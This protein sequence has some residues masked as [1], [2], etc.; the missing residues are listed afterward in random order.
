MSN[1]IDKKSD[2]INL[3]IAFSLLSNLSMSINPHFILST[4]SLFFRLI[5]HKIQLSKH[6]L[7]SLPFKQKIYHSLSYKTLHSFTNINP[8]QHKNYLVNI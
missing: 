6:S 3:S 1:F 4:I 8:F 2:R 7:R 5:F